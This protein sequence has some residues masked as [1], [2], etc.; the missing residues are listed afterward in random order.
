VTRYPA[1]EALVRAV[2]DAPQTTPFV[3]LVDAR[4]D[5]RRWLDSLDGSEA[6]PPARREAQGR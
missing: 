4:A 1:L 5:A 3:M 2:L 6:P